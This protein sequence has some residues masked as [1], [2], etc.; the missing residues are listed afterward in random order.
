[1]FFDLTKAYDSVPRELLWKLISKYGVPEVMVKVL[2]SLHEGME[3]QVRVGGK[4]SDTIFVRNGLRQGC[5]MSPVLFNL[6]F[7]AVMRM[8]REECLGDDGCGI[9]IEVVNDKGRLTA[10]TGKK[11]KV[12]RLSELCFADD[13][14]AAATT[15]AALVMMVEKFIA[16]CKRWGLAVS[17]KK[18]EFMVVGER[19]EGDDMDPIVVEGGSILAVESF[20]YLGSMTETKGGGVVEADVNRRL[21]IASSVFGSMRHSVWNDKDLSI[22]TKRIVF[23][24]CVWGTLNFGM[25][26]WAIP[27]QL[28]AKLE[29]FYNRCLRTIA[30]VTRRQQREERITSEQIRKMTG[31][32][33]KVADMMRQQRLRW[34]GHVGRMDEKRIPYQLMFGKLQGVSSRGGRKLR[35]KDRVRRDLREVGIDEGQWLE[36]AQDREVWEQVCQRTGSVVAAAVERRSCPVC[37]RSDLKG[38]RGLAA[39]ARSCNPALAG[40]IRNVGAGMEVVLEGREGKRPMF[41]CTG[42]GEVMMKT[43]VGT[44]RH[45]AA[46]GNQRPPAIKMSAQAREALGAEFQCGTCR[47]KFKRRQDLTQHVKKSRKGCGT[48][49]SSSSAT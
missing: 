10:R 47:L 3:A 9:A 14:A 11:G 35:W 4:L 31:M 6:F 37:G 12:V 27:A 46:C 17:I 7:T 13:A 1:M 23:T 34:L 30:G 22:K 48:Q 15:R 20:K 39:H 29:T 21:A 26:S 45:A 19:E 24:A 2:S 5:T 44:R 42:C 32:E 8:W 33:R 41:K 16:V 28:V 40:D 49:S 36:V 43:L 38:A 25:E 18:S